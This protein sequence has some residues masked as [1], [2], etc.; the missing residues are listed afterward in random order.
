[1][2]SA[3]KV[4]WAQLRVGIVA[5][6]AM[7]ILGLLVVLLTGSTKWFAKTSMLSTFM[8]DSANMSK[9]SPVR[10]NGIPAG[11]VATVEWSGLPG[12]RAVKMTMEIETDKL[13]QIPVDSE[14]AIASE[15]ALGNKFINIRK[16]ESPETVKP[17]A[18]LK[19]QD[20]SGFDDVVASGYAVMV[21]AKVML[22]RMDGI[23]SVIESGKG[24]IGKL[25]NDDRLYDN[26]AKTAEEAAKIT[27]AVNSDKGSIGKLL[28]GTELHDDLRSAIARVNKLVDGL[29]AG[30]GTAGKLLKDTALYDEF[31]A[32]AT[33]ARTLM[34]DLNAG[35]GT[36]G[37]LLK[38]EALHNQIVSTIARMDTLLD[39]INSGEG[40]LGQLVV[41]PQLYDSLNGTAREMNLLMKDFRANP[42]KFL[43]IKLGLF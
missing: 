27:V 20:T 12:R 26:L 36:A 13:P 17:G 34:A 15:N 32:T 11:K 7:V 21:S 10:I 19:S 35:K 25:I 37:K 2:P 31:K 42:K 5:M 22:E 28:H 14:V 6:V 33:E 38:D 43:R 8:T 4:S 39:K 29:E 18:E 9:G 23:V 41:N 40:S 16:G 30:Q 24:S 3:Q 1:M